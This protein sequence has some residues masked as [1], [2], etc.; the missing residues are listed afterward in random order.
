M[1]KCVIFF[2]AKEQLKAQWRKDLDTIR[3]SM[4]PLFYNALTKINYES[5]F[6]TSQ[7]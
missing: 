5:E 6:Q 1:P 4:N 7:S 2:N 3:Y